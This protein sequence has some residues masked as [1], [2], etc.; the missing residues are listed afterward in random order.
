MANRDLETV[1]LRSPDPSAIVRRDT[2]RSA[3]S[4]RLKAD[5]PSAETGDRVVI[6]GRD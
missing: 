3:R 4:S 5:P 1:V 6:P 2:N